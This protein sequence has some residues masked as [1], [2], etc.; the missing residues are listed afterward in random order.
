MNLFCRHFSTVNFYASNGAQLRLCGISHQFEIE[1]VCKRCRK[2]VL[3]H[4]HR[5]YS[6][7]ADDNAYEGESTEDSQ[8]VN[9][10]LHETARS[11]SPVQ[12]FT[13]TK[14]RCVS[15]L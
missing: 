4:T 11:S 12:E 15:M 5:V 2:G 10:F 9:L 14:R 8:F 1:K 7:N 3:I 6:N 13:S